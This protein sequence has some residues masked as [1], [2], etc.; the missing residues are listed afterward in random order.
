MRPNKVRRFLVLAWFGV[1]FA[2]SLIIFTAGVAKADYSMRS[3]HL[4]CSAGLSI[5]GVR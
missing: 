4:G 2:G 1:L 3:P 5:G